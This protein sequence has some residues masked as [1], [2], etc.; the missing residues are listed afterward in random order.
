[1]LD[2]IAGTGAEPFTAEDL[3]ASIPR[4]GRA[5]VFRT[6]RLLQELDL[7]CRVP[8][9]D[10][11]VRYQRSRGEHHHHLICSSC[12]TVTEFSD[13]QLDALILDQ[14]SRRRFALDSHSMELYGRCAKC[15]EG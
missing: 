1:M 12:G 10:G 3:A 14:A 11:S 9:E 7:I 5:T 13:P 15:A 6:I 4:V 8:L 2:A